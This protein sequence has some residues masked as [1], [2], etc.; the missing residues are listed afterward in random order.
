MLLGN[1]MQASFKFC[2]HRHHSWVWRENFNKF[3]LCAHVISCVHTVG[4]L[5]EDMWLIPPQAK[6][7][8]EMERHGRAGMNRVLMEV[9]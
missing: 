3:Q 5:P 1:W 4:V 8:W 6:P 2:Q 9:E 7:D